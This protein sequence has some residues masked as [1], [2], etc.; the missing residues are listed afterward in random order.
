MCHDPFWSRAAQRQGIPS[1]GDTVIFCIGL[2]LNFLLGVATSDL[3]EWRLSKGRGILSSVLPIF[4]AVCINVGFWIVYISTAA[5]WHL[6]LLDGLSWRLDAV[7]WY[8]ILHVTYFQ[9]VS[10]FAC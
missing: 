10:Q 8:I 4:V 6:I 1:P 7:F 5:E 3:S 9:F 2:I